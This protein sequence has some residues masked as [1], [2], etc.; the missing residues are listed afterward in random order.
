MT[1]TVPSSTELD[2]G[3]FLLTQSN[4]IQAMG[5][6]NPIQ[7]T[8]GSNPGPTLFFQSSARYLSFHRLFVTSFATRFTAEQLTRKTETQGVLSFPSAQN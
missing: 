4:P 6:S 3:S 1:E 5:G 7:A 2:I 8:G